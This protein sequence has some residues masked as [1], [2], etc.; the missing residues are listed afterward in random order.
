MQPRRQ[1]RG[2]S[3]VEL[4]VVMALI[5]LVMSMLVPA[6]FKLLKAVRHLKGS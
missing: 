1:S 6:A 3:L 2:I 5:A 4:M